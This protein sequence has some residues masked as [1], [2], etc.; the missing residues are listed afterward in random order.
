MSLISKSDF[1]VWSGDPVTKAYKLAIVEAIQ[2][3]KEALAQSAGLDQNEDNFRR[4]YVCAM[5]D[6]LDF[7][8]DDLQETDDGN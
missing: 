7:K 5:M 2:Q 4:G 8:I 1:D 3:I 6:V